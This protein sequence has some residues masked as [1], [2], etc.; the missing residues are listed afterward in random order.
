[1]FVDNINPTI[2]SFGP[3]EIRYYGLVY[4]IGF[5]FVYWLLRKNS[6]VIG[7]SLE[8]ID[9]LLVYLLIGL[10]AGSRLFEAIFWQPAYYFAHPLRIFY[11]WQGGMSF[12][13]ALVGLIFA[14]WLFT[15]QNKKINFLRLADII[16]LPAML[17]L[18][19]GRIANFIN[20]ELPG[21][22]TNV[23]WCVKFPSAPNPAHRIG[24]RHPSQ[25]YESLHHFIAFFIML[26]LSFKKFK[27]GFMFL[28]FILLYGIGRFI[29]DF[30]RDDP[31]IIFGINLGQIFSLL[32]VFVAIYFLIKDYKKDIKHIITL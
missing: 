12:H 26:P 15:R 17:I 14:G 28:I 16:S 18:A 31:N 1:M 20:G 23:S 19:F 30:Y 29:T 7:L 8:K 11:I 24:C 27:D 3:F 21:K 9:E 22:I 32:M 10:L 25:L 4:V 6:K 2:V 5:L 13:G